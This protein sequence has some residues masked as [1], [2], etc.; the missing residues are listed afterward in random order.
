MNAE[1]ARRQHRYRNRILIE[2][3]LDR[4]RGMSDQI[5]ANDAWALENFIRAYSAAYPDT[6]GV[7]MDG[8]RDRHWRHALFLSIEC[9]PVA[10]VEMILHERTTQRP[11]PVSQ[12]ADVDL[13]GILR[14]QLVRSNHPELHQNWRS[15]SGKWPQKSEWLEAVP[16]AGNA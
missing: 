1:I 14:K 3:L 6:A 9:D 4:L 10:A 16:P 12:C 15:W 2:G 13:R 11:A 5:S 7:I 8:W